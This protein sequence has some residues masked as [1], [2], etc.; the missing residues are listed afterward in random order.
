MISY[1][2]TFDNPLYDFEVPI[3]K[4]INYIYC[5]FPMYLYKKLLTIIVIV[6][7]LACIVIEKYS[8]PLS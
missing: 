2:F 4:F 1:E 5:K 7:Y 8:Y 3:L 6:L